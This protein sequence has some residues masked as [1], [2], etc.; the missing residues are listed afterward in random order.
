MSDFGITPAKVREGQ[1]EEGPEMENI[2][3]MFDL[4]LLRRVDD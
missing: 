1:P 3:D 4:R 2:S